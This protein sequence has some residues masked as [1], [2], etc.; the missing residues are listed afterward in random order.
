MVRDVDVLI[1]GGGWTGVSAALTFHAYNT[2]HPDSPLT[3]AL[4]EGHPSRLGGRA[5]SYGYEWKDQTG[6]LR[7]TSF[8]H[9]AQYVGRSQS[10]L[11]KLIQ[12]AIEQG[13]LSP[14][15]LVDGYA[16][17]LPY[18]E[19]VMMIAGR[20]YPYDRDQ[21]L[22]GIGGV[23][24][25]LGLWDVMGV[26]VIVGL[27][28]GVEQSIN[29]LSPWESPAWVTALDG[30][31]LLQWL[32][33][34]GLPPGARSLLR[35]SV[36]AVIS[37]EA[38]QVSA[39]YFFW[40]CA[41]NGGFLNEVNDEQGGPQQFYLA[42][43][44]DTLIEKLAAPVAEQIFREQVVKNVDHKS[45]G[46]VTVT[47]G[48]STFRA[49]KVIVATSPAS[50]SRMSF[51][52]PLP[53]A[54]QAITSQSMGTTVKCQVFYKS[55]WWRNVAA[56][57]DPQKEGVPQYT[58]YCGA[59]DYPVIWVMDYSPVGPG[60]RYDDQGCYALMTF[61][62]GSE[63][64][65][66]L[67][68]PNKEKIVEWVTTALCDLF[69]DSRAL[70][71]SSEY[72]DLKWFSW[73]A[74]T[75]LIPGGPNTVFSPG[76][77]TGSEAPAKAFDSSVGGKVY[78]AAAEL[79]CKSPGDRQSPAATYVP[80]WQTL[81]QTGTY[82]DFRQSLG[83]MDGAVTCG[84]FVAEQVLADLSLQQKA[85]TE[86]AA[87]GAQ[88]VTA[89]NGSAVP[90]P[91]NGAPP[92]PAPPPIPEATL[93][94]GLTMLCQRLYAA[95]APP[96]SGTTE[97]TT[98]P[99]DLQAWLAGVL[100]EML[101]TNGLLTAPP[102]TPPTGFNEAQAIVYMLEMALWQ[103]TFVAVSLNFIASGYALQVAS[104]PGP[105]NQVGELAAIASTLMR[106]KSV[107]PSASGGRLASVGGAVRTAASRAE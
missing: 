25:D 53:A 22:F 86:G 84:R 63:A 92:A 26:L 38:D 75:S 50:V 47:T 18:K 2:A 39:F 61:T 88:S 104:P 43:G 80:S 59:N 78:F 67:T 79:S 62:I 56:Q 24:P 41:C 30:V 17:R 66:L 54:W 101:V 76:I 15:E 31:T 32:D 90:P 12:Q 58:G 33:S 5:F 93:C 45:D 14:D 107:E 36:E 64:K 70:S 87:Y 73:D 6:A 96:G 106:L 81:G 42:S 77:L 57:T 37:V 74:A 27:I 89:A 28:Q 46:S 83:Y 19:Q 11:W 98:D 21:A 44:L 65:D 20:R 72:I 35:V 105:A 85:T 4:L 49:K 29:V 60:P 103:P 97:S 9:G 94:A 7:T 1:V 23:P 99:G 13:L 69:N 91:A 40:Y 34:L 71:S 100:I 3:F 51:D 95:S 48:G 68:N 16:A 102:A 82:S 8:E 52:P 10:A 55:P